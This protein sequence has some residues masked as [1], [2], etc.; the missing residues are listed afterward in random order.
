MQYNIMIKGL[1]LSIDILCCEPIFVVENES[2]VDHLE[3]KSILIRPYFELSLWERWINSQDGNFGDNSYFTSYTGTFTF[4]HFLDLQR[5]VVFVVLY[6]NKIFFSNSS[7]K[8]N[9]ESLFWYIKI[10]ICFTTIMQPLNVDWSWLF[11][12]SV[13]DTDCP[14]TA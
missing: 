5:E 10:F 2:N 6:K 7:Q 14:M 4:I 1:W 13:I 3:I 12:T 11:L 8:K 9:S